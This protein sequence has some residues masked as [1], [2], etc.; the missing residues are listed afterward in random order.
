VAAYAAAG[1]SA[2]EMGNLFLSLKKRD[3]WDPSP[4]TKPLLVPEILQRM[5]RLS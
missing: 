2:R 5:V 4:G 1:M 3:F